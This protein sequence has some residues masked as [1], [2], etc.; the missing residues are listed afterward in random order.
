M[1]LETTR[2][3]NKDDEQRPF[4]VHSLKQFLEFAESLYIQ[5]SGS[6]DSNTVTVS[7]GT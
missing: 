2:L 1:L 5:L 4:I 7:E 3:R 6:V